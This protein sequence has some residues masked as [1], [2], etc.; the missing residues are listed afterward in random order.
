[1]GIPSIPEI[2]G[3]PISSK[4]KLSDVYQYEIMDIEEFI[5]KVSQ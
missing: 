3:N 4:R 5:N 2:P 1:M